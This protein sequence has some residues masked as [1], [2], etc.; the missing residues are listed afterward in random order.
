METNETPADGYVVLEYEDVWSEQRHYLVCLRGGSKFMRQ[1]QG[2]GARQW[3]R[4]L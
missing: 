4:K 2:A 1:R 3:K